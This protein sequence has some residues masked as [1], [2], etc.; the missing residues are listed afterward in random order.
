MN[1]QDEHY[2][3]QAS[4]QD[5]INEAYRSTAPDEAY[6]FYCNHCNDCR[7][8]G[9][10]AGTFEDFKKSL[11]AFTPIEE[12]EDLLM[13]GQLENNPSEYDEVPF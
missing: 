3:D 4:S 2:Q 5:Y 10:D 12:N 8:M 1:Q 7:E 11:E 9:L 6:E 13:M